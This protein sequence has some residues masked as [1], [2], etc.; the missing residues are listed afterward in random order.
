MSNAVAKPPLNPW[1]NSHGTARLCRTGQKTS[2]S[3][4]LYD[5]LGSTLFEAI[6]LLP[7]YGLTR[8]EERILRRHAR[9][10]SSDTCRIRRWYPNSEAE[11][12]ER[13][14]G[15]S[16]HSARREP[17][18][19]Y[20]IEISRAAL[21]SCESELSDIDHISI[22]GVE[23]EYLDGLREVAAL[24]AGRHA[25][26]GPVSGQHHRQF[27]FRGGC[28][29]FCGRFGFSAAGRFAAAWHRSR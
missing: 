21:A 5:P 11:A 3:K 29:A 6:S 14:A 4:Y 1:S 19:Y 2:P 15:Y 10:K 18:S 24:R 26:A 13:P 8:A 28:C 22:V 9:G 20:P 23:R 17:L 25:S 7:E 27:R 16:A 12:A